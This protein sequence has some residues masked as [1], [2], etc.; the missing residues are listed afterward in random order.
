MRGRY[1]SGGLLLLAIALI[2]SASTPIVTAESPQSTNYQLDETT[3]GSGGLIQSSS[4]N[5][6]TSNAVNDLAVGNATSA[7]FQVE[8]GSQ[9]THDPT[10]SFDIQNM[11]VNFGKFSASTPAVSS[12]TFSV[13][14]YT[15]YGYVVQLVGNAPTNG[16]HVIN[17]LG[18]TTASL[19][20]TEQFG[21]NLVANTS[22]QSIGA[23]PQNGAFGFGEIAPSYSTAN[24]F[25]YV[26]GETI[27]LAPK[28]SGETLYTLSYLVNVDNLTPGGI[29][30]SNQ[31]LIVTG[32][33]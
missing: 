20:G 13:K 7:N 4:T 5:F 25:R 2:A 21:V 14:N 9:T 18:S 22:P 15:S 31:T 3:V 29:Y 30:T 27:A 6:K 11:D 23:N 12:A 16:T 8:A 19:P 32:R 24:M 10:L 33:Y 28:S 1:S 26:S 17:P